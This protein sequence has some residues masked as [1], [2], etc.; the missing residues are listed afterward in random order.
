VI[1]LHQQGIPIA[2]PRSVIYSP[3]QQMQAQVPAKVNS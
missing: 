1:S 3:E 2:Y